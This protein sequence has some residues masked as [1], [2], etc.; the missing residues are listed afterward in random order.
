MFEQIFGIVAPVLV[1]T[2]V[3]WL[4]ARAGARVDKTSVLSLVTAIGIPT[5]V[6]ATLVKAEVDG[7][8]L[9]LV[10]GATLLCLAGFFAAGILGLR[11]AGLPLRH[12][13]PAVSFPNTGNLGLALSLLAF[14]HEGLAYGIVFFAITSVFNHTVGVA[15]AIG[16]WRPRELL[17]VPVMHATILAM[18]VKALAI[19]VPGW[20]L[21]T[22]T[23]L[24]SMV[25]PIML[26]M[27]GI[28]LAELK[29]ADTKRS[30]ALALLRLGSG[31]AIGIGVATALGLGPVARGVVIIQSAMP[32]AVVT[33]LY[34]A[35]FGNDATAVAGTI[36]LSTLIGFAI[37][38]VVL[39]I[40]LP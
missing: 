4:W 18:L 3:G 30:A 23:M 12:F 35:K 22:A 1:S 9:L 15:V 31:L 20:V 37:L 34:A 17:R 33:Y 36:F 32:T 6:F 38:P 11:L 25:V 29:L 14:G 39:W 24:G 19:P 27:L 7:P 8:R 28:S 13:L 21:G 16:A 10:G 5:L 2:A 26:V 40:A